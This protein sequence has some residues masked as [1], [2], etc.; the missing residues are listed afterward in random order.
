M[1]VPEI[2]NIWKAQ[3]EKGEIRV[4]GI[5]RFPNISY[6]L[7][8]KKHFWNTKDISV[9]VDFL[10]QKD[11]KWFV[12]NLFAVQ[13]TIPEQLFEPF[14]D[15]A[16]N[17]SDPSLNKEY[18][19][20][21]LRVF[22]FQRVFVLLDQRFREGNNQVKVGVCKAYYWARSPLVKMSKGDGPWETKGHLTKWNGHYYGTY[23][24]ENDVFFEMTQLEVAECQK[25]S[26]PLYARRNKLLIEEF[27]HNRDIDVRY[28]IKLALPER[29]SSFF[30]LNKALA[31][32]YFQELK[33]N[34]V[35]ENSAD[36]KLKKRLGLLGNH[37]LFRFFV[38]MKNKRNKKK[39]LISLKN[40]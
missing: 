18:I 5:D 22:G 3:W 38:K 32:A 1:T 20:P 24:W 40:K 9:L 17:E 10:K 30:K 35:P 36:L 12:A 8:E 13:K 15:A 27:L 25:V 16:I 7:R 4:H 34:H 26:A 21:C 28:Q 23:D 29:E 39:G 2:Y 19:N 11:K 31:K 33:N 6:K 14:I 37:R